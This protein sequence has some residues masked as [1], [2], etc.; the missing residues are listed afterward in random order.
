M[1]MQDF[2]NIQ[3]L[4]QSGKDNDLPDA[5]TIINQIRRFRKKL[6][7]KNVIGAVALCLTFLW[8]GFVGWYFHFEKWTTRAGIILTLVAIILGVVFNSRLIQLLVRQGDTALDNKKFLA[9]MVHFRNAQRVI[10]RKGMLVYYI[11][12]TIGLCLYMW[13][14]AERS[15]FFAIIAY[16][17]SLGWIIFSWIYFNKKVASKQEQRLS[18]QIDRLE[19]VVHEME[20]K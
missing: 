6:I 2:D 5:A 9:Q 8:V 13:E 17:L 1:N 19:S 14:F 4:W 15:F 3:K 20:E 7:R 10:R 18:E 12:L 11:L 16:P